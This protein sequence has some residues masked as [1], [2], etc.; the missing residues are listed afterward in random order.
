MVLPF[1]EDKDSNVYLGVLMCLRH[2]IPNLNSSSSN[3]QRMKGL[4]GSFGSQ[5]SFS[6]DSPH[7][8]EHIKSNQLH[9]VC[10][11]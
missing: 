10:T 1:H 11:K 6:S 9:Q 2:M 5:R 8:D 4:R 3:E 7:A